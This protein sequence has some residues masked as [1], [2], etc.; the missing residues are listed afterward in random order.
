[1]IKSLK[2]RRLLYVSG[3]AVLLLYQN[4]A[5]TPDDASSFDS[6]SYTDTLPFAYDAKID[7]IGYMSC[8]DMTN[9]S[10][11]PRAY[12]TFRAGAYNST[13]GGLGMTSDFR[14]QTQYYTNTDRGQA[15]ASSSLNAN[16]LLSLSVRSTSN[17]QSPLYPADGTLSAGGNLDAFL[18]PLDSP[19]IAGPFASVNPGQYINYFPGPG[20]QRLM[21][22][23]LRFLKSENDAQQNRNY[24]N[25]AAALL[26]AGYSGSAD[27]LDTTLR[28]PAPATPTTPVNNRLAYGT[29]YRL[30][31]ALPVGYSSGQLRVLSTAGIQEVDLTTGNAKSATWDCGSNYE[32][33]VV[34]PEDKAAGRVICNAG[35]DR[36]LNSTQ[37]QAL[38]VI[39]RV[40]R[41]EDWYV[42]LD[43]HC[44]MPKGTGGDYCYGTT[45]GNKVIQYG[46]AS[47]YEDATSATK[48]PHFV[49]VCVRQ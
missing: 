41:V 44:V 22:A 47:C 18:P 16:T 34:R 2:S 21:E 27:V 49:S 1:M 28:V 45:L 38:N 24:F 23:S 5:Q 13:T 37:Q 9:T 43:N 30:N 17:M 15:L 20:S 40:L 14:T 11:E 25:G 3:V 36:Y 31:F 33:M 4:C 12:F 29:G 8:S 26:V 19:D 10:Y 35:V 32:F 48:C 7:T 46:V 39:R 6:Q 42:D